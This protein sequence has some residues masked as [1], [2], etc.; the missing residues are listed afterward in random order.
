M[1]KI[2]AAAAVAAG[3][4]AL[5]ACNMDAGPKCLSSHMETTW[6]TVIGPKGAVS[7]HPAFYTV[8]DRYETPTP[9]ASAG[10]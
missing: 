3:M 7:V 2:V 10:A 4:L 8:C 9:K 1:R 5:S 6:V